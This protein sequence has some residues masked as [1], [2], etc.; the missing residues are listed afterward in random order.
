M[1]AVQDI[2]EEEESALADRIEKRVRPLIQ[3]EFERVRRRYP[4]LNAILFGNGTHFFDFEKGSRFDD[5]NARLPKAF[6]TLEDMATA[7]N[8][9]GPE[10]ITP[11]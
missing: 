9:Y 4:A 7:V 10:D 2:V 8:Q 3:A 11:E 1:Q 5:F 6:D